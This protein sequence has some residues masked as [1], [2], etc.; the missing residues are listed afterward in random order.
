MLD[1]KSFYLSVGKKVKQARENRSYTQEELA[2]KVSLSRTSITNIEQGRQQFMLHTLI[3]I[4]AA[5]AVTPASLLP[6]KQDT[7][8]ADT[9]DEKLKEL[10]PNK[11]RWIKSALNKS[12]KTRT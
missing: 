1:R 12:T 8:F 3:E 5:L 11:R 7:K 9:L 6:E 4:A 2:S 10:S